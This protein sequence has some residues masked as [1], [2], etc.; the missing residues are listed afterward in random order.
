MFALFHATFRTSRSATIASA[1][2][3]LISTS[4]MCMIVY[5]HVQEVL[6]GKPRLPSYAI[7]PRIILMLSR[8]AIR[9]AY[10]ATAKP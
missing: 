6:C 1:G 2:V 7:M 10:S 5:I 9:F 4:T 8:A 3:L